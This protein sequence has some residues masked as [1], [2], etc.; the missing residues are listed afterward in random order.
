MILDS[1]CALRGASRESGCIKL[2][3]LAQ[4]ALQ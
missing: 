3:L 4:E 2:V 1:P